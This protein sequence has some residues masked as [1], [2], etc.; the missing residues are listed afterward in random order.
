MKRVAKWVA[1]VYFIAM[2]VA[3]TFPGITPF[4][5]I[6]PYVLG[7]PFVFAWY[8]LWILGAL[9]VFAVLDR[10]YRE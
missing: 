5:T 1:I 10:L 4:N 7:V 2:A 9:T 3:L 6:H 8:V